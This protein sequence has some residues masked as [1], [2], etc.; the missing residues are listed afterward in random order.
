MKIEDIIKK[1]K[2]QLDI[3]IPDSELWNNIKNEWKEGSNKN[4]FSW[5]KVAALVFIS[6][7]FGLLMYSLSLK[8][9]VNETS[10]SWRHF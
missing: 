6:L 3:E 2:N 4:S 1:Q 10:K 8:N 7:S 5:W 9:Q